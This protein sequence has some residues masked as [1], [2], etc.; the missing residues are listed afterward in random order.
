[1]SKGVFFATPSFDCN[2]TVEHSGSMVNAVKL[3]QARGY[4]S[5]LGSSLGCCF[6]DRAR[7]KLVHYFLHETDLDDFF[8]IDADIGFDYRVIPHFLDSPHEIV[9]G[10]PPKRNYPVE[11]HVAGATNKVEHGC[12]EVKDAPTAFMRI[13][14]SVFAQMDEKYEFS[15]SMIE[16]L[17]G[18]DGAAPYFQCGV[19]NGGFMGEDIFFCRLWAAL[20]KSIWVMPNIEFTHR[21]SHPFKGNLWTHFIDTK[22]VTLKE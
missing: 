5:V 22:Q 20:G 16:G 17:P 4:D 19:F 13:K 9:V 12:F 15:K 6:V 21:G 3:L 8:F 14:R 2:V 1:M 10:I 11:Y 18:D 7:C